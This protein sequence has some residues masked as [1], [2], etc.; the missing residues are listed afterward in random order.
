MNAKPTAHN[1]LAGVDG[2]KKG[3]II[4]SADDWPVDGSL[5]IS[6]VEAFAEVLKVTSG[7]TAVAVDMPIGLVSAHSPDGFRR[8]CDLEARTLLGGAASSR[9]FFTPPYESIH[10]TTANEFQDTH[11]HLTGTGAGL[12][13]WGIVAKIAE[14][15]ASMTPELQERVFEF[16]PELAWMRLAGKV[17]ASKHNAAGI[18]ERIRTLEDLGFDLRDVEGEAAL[19][20]AAID[21]LL[22]ALVGLVVAA[23]RVKDPPTA[24]RIPDGDPP[25]GERDLRL[26]I[27]Y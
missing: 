14:V 7:A 4:A 26:E 2:C 25:T 15:N 8:G 20:G 17:L 5:S 19:A 27:W 16:H 11:R 21:D 1:A 13:V 9:V 6:V 12:P 18:V 23:G 3:W 22:D 10:A 24:R